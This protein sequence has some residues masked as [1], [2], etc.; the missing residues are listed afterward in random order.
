MKYEKAHIRRWNILTN[1]GTGDDD[2]ESKG[3]AKNKW[4]MGNGGGAMGRNMVGQWSWPI[5]ENRSVA[6]RI[7]L[8]TK[9]CNQPDGSNTLFQSLFVIKTYLW[10]ELTVPNNLLQICIR[11]VKWYRA[12]EISVQ[13]NDFG[14]EDFTI[15]APVWRVGSATERLINHQSSITSQLAVNCH[16]MRS[17]FSLGGGKWLSSPAP[18]SFL[19]GICDIR[20][21]TSYSSISNSPFEMWTNALDKTFQITFFYHPPARPSIRSLAQPPARPSARSPAQAFTRSFARPPA[22]LT[23]EK[24]DPIPKKYLKRER[25]RERMYISEGERKREREREGERARACICPK[26]RIYFCEVEYVYVWERTCTTY[27]SERD[28]VMLKRGNSFVRI[29]SERDN[30]CVRVRRCF[31]VIDWVPEQL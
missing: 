26:E 15:S 18:G 11:C 8:F 24:A 17:F 7:Q 21:R 23:L 4:R 2:G 31:G 30:V 16:Y 1:E 12:M 28:N 19:H 9:H 6:K 3:W 20:Q 13:Q 5:F 10:N 27:K 14:F 29:L 22:D 25:E